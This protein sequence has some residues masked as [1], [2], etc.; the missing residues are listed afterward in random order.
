MFSYTLRFSFRTY[1]IFFLYFWINF[2]NHSVTRTK[3]RLRLNIQ[4]HFLFT[5]LKQSEYI[6]KSLWRIFE[7]RDRPDT[8]ESGN[9]KSPT[10]KK[11]TE[12]NYWIK[13]RKKLST[14]SKEVRSPFFFSSAFLT[15]L[16]HA[17]DSTICLRSGRV[18]NRQKNN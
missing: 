3:H 5:P 13:T 6:K 12:K 2:G 1:T 14:T 10:R 16:R 7:R 11:I 9:K 4:R 15:D 18:M 8:G 17:R